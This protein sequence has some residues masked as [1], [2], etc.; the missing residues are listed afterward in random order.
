MWD[1]LGAWLVQQPLHILLVAAG[2]LPVWAAVRATPMRDVPGANVFWAPA[3]AWLAYAGWE[4]LVLQRSPEADL[5][6]ELLVIWPCL[7]LL[8]A[9]AAVRA[10]GS[11]RRMH[12]CRNSTSVGPPPDGK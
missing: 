9:W 1:V 2:N 6:V 8:T 5:R 10:A 11:L 3:I 4:W 12:A 7:A